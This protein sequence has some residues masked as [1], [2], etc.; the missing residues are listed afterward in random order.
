MRDDVERRFELS[1]QS[2]QNPTPTVQ[3][4]EIGL[5]EQVSVAKVLTVAGV[6][7]GAVAGLVAILTEK[8]E[9][10]SKTEN[11]KAYLRDALA[12]AQSKDFAKDAR[13]RGK[14]AEKKLHKQA[15]SATSDLLGFLN[16][17]E[18]Q[19]KSMERDVS[20]AL[21]D[22][23]KGASKSAD[24]ARSELSSLVDLIREKS[25]DIEKQAEH[26]AESTLMQKLRE[27]GEEARVIAEDGKMKGADL[28]HKAQEDVLPQAKDA[29]VHGVQ[30]GKE[31]A[32]DIADKAKSDYIPH[33]Q[34]FAA[35]VTEQARDVAS[36]LGA[37]AGAKLADAGHV[38]EEKAHQATEA[39]KRG[40]RETRSLLMWV[41]LAG[42]LIF[43]VFLDEEQQKK[44]K[45]VAVE[46][47]GEAR[48]MYGD[49]KGNTQA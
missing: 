47:F 31:K 22:A 29:V 15:D 5:P 11:A 8:E 41:A 46:V 40:G 9:P 2:T 20:A 7:A 39:V 37:D 25:Q 13:K 16:R 49:M 10:V 17:A 1:E 30:V 32:S 21:K 19:G 42:I 3:V 36:T 23:K 27:F 35:G 24:T 38:A 34:E 33:A 18:K 48:D 14:R 12:Q 26:F 43:T 44:L 45:E 4:K 28:A 6:A